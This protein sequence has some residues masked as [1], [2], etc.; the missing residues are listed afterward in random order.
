MARIYL[1]LIAMEVT[2]A[3]ID[4]VG[5]VASSHAANVLSLFLTVSNCLAID[6]LQRFSLT[7]V[8]DRNALFCSNWVRYSCLHSSTMAL[9]S[10]RFTPA[11]A[12]IWLKTRPTAMM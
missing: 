8:M 6:L 12:P 7:R 11:F 3:S 9:F 10:Y 4:M 1:A 5:D 2:S